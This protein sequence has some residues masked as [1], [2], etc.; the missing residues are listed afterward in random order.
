VKK[1]QQ[2]FFIREKIL[3]QKANKLG[4]YQANLPSDK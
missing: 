2:E 1:S 3:A 4:I